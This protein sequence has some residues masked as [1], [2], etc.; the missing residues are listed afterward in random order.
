MPQNRLGL[1][2]GTSKWPAVV[3]I[4]PFLSDLVAGVICM[5]CIKNAP[6]SLGIHVASIM[7]QSMLKKYGV[8]P[9]FL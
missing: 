1:L 9:Y 3:L 6:S 8:L 2:I 5:G 7:T 4:V